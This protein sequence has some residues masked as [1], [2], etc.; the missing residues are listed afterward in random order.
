MSC[1]VLLCTD[2]GE[3]DWYLLVSM[4]FISYLCSY[5]SWTPWCL[6]IMYYIIPTHNLTLIT[7]NVYSK[8]LWQ[9]RAGFALPAI[10]QTRNRV[11]NPLPMDKRLSSPD[12]RIEIHELQSETPHVPTSGGGGDCEAFGGAVILTASPKISQRNR[13]YRCSIQR[14]FIFL[15]HKVNVKYR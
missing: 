1:Y 6:C 15:S 10:E 11:E 7:Q 3:K 12:G 5:Q 4:V 2:K 8:N 9:G 13:K 14:C